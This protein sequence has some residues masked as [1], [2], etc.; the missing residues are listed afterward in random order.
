MK[1]G[2]V[3]CLFTREKKWAVLVGSLIVQEDVLEIVKRTGSMNIVIGGPFTPMQYVSMR[4]M[5][6]E[7]TGERLREFDYEAFMKAAGSRKSVREDGGQV[8]LFSFRQRA[9]PDPCSACLRLL[10]S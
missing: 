8:L 9:R 6:A 7:I 4:R 2:D 5:K 1:R 10:P 3:I